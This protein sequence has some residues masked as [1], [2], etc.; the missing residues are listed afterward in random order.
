MLWLVTLPKA[1]RTCKKSWARASGQPVHPLTASSASQGGNGDIPPSLSPE[2]VQQSCL[3]IHPLL[4]NTLCCTGHFPLVC[5]ELD[6]PT[7]IL[8][9]ELPPCGQERW[10][11]PQ[12][13]PVALTSMWACCKTQHDSTPQHRAQCPVQQTAEGNQVPVRTS[14]TVPGL[15]CSPAMGQ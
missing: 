11:C 7:F 5:L 3:G 2:Q 12:P 1:S 9:S 10:F 15:L 4:R 8:H 6:S 14:K 13:C